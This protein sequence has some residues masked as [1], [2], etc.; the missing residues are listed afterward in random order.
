VEWAKAWARTKRWTEEVQ[1][2]KEEMRRVPITL[3]WKADWWSERADPDGLTGAHAE[4]AHAY[5]ARQAHLLRALAAHFETMWAGLAELEEVPGEETQRAEDLA[6]S[7]DD[8]N[9]NEDEEDDGVGDE[10]GEDMMEG[11]EEGSVGGEDDAE[12]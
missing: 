3:R 9:E 10:E 6:Q 1:L 7:G 11:D 12:D 8:E 2:L 5:A 4:G